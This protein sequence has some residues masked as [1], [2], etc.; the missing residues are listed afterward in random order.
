MKKVYLDHNATAPLR[1]EARKALEEALD[2][3]L[4]N[5]SSVHHRGRAARAAE[6]GQARH[7]LARMR[8]PGATRA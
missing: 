5:P 4:G 7:L 6:R 8:G 2:L 3:G 1:P